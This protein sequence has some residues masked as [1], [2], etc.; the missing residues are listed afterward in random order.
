M[1]LLWDDAVLYHGHGLVGR[2]GKVVE[3][4]SLGLALI[5]LKLLLDDIDGKLV[6][7]KATRSDVLGNLRDLHEWR[8]SRVVGGDG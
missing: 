3:K 5:T 4:P 6:G 1:H 7:H 8:G 2:A